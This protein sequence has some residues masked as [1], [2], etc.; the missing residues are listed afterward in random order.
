MVK[1]APRAKIIA[2]DRPRLM[3][4]LGWER[5]KRRERKDTPQPKD[6]RGKSN[7]SN[8]SSLNIVCFSLII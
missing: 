7:N 2:Q 1:K 8:L 5:D 6:L 4:K 3:A